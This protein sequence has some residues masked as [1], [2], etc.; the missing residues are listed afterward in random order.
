MAIGQPAKV[1]RIVRRFEPPPE[2]VFDAGIDPGIAGRRLFTGPTSESRA[3]D[4][5]A[6]V[7]GRWTTADVRDGITSTAIG[8]Y[9]E[10][11]RPRRLAFTFEMPQFDPNADRVTAEIAP[12]GAGRG[13]TLTQEGI[14]ID[15]ELDQLPPDA[16][17][18]SASGWGSMFGGRAAAQGQGR[19]GNSDARRCGPIS[20]LAGNLTASGW[21]SGRDRST[22]WG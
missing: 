13:L 20:N 10:I 4:L 16:I 9:A 12:D 6:R 8:E 14:G 21:G 18:D 19:A 7:G 5:D 1:L 22:S 2:R 15:E 3:A 17:G 11:D